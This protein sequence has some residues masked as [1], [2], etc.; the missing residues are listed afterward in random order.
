MM[1]ISPAILGIL[2]V[3]AV[4]PSRGDK[5]IAAGSRPL[6][7]VAAGWRVEVVA[8]APAILFPTAIV[9]AP[10]G[11]IYLGQDPM[12][13][14]GPP[15]RPGDS[16]VA[17]RDG[18]VRV[19]AEGLWAVM[20]LEWIDRTLYVV[21]APF[22]SALT[23]TDGDGRADRRVDLVTGLGPDVPGFSGINDHVASG[24]RL[25]SD[26]FLYVAVGDKGIPHA[27]GTDG[28]TIRLHGGGVVRVR[29]D[30][31]GLEVVSTGERNPLSVALGDRDEVFTYGNDDDSKQWPNSLTHHIVGGHYGYPYEFLQAPWRA[32][33]IVAGDL[34][35]S[36]TQGV[37]LDE[38]GFSP[39]YR[40][41]LAFC[42]WGLQSVFRYE[43]AP[44]GATFRLVRREPLMTRG[45]LADFRPFSIAIDADRSSLLV[46]DWAFPGWLAAGPRTGRLFRLRYDGD[47]RDIAPKPGP[48]P[49][50]ESP[51]STWLAALDHPSRTIRLEGQRRLASG[52]EAVL[53]EVR[54][55]LVDPKAPARARIHA[56]WTLDA[57]GIEPPTSS[58]ADPS[59]D[60][61]SESARRAGIRRIKGVAPALRGLLTDGDPV[62]RREAAIALGRVGSRED[63]PALLDSISD[64]DAFVAW[65]TRG[66]IRALG[67]WDGGSLARALAD[68]ARRDAALILADES[69]A[70][71]VVA[72]LRSAFAGSTDAPFR[73]RVL[74]NLAGQYRKYP[75]WSGRWFGTNPLA[76]AF[77]TRTVDWDP[78]AMAAIRAGLTDGLA[79]REAEVRRQA[80]VG[81]G[82]VGPDA[83]RS[84]VE[85]FRAESD[86]T[87]R[88]AIVAT[89]GRWPVEPGVTDLLIGVLG[90]KAEPVAT[91]IEAL[92]ALAATPGRPALNARFTLAYDRGA[93]ADLVARA[94]VPLGRAGALPANDLAG[95]LDNPDGPV[96]AAAMVGFRDGS[97]PPDHVRAKFVAGLDDA[98]PIARSAAI[99]TVARLKIP[100]AVDRLVALAGDERTRVEATRALAIV[101]DPRALD[102][103][104]AAAGDRDPEV[105]KVGELALLAIRDREGVVDRL[106]ARARAGEF[107]GP[108]ASSVERALA[109]FRPVTTWRVIG[110]F[111]R[112]T[113]RVFVGDPAID[114]ARTHAGVE[115]RTI[116][117]A[118][119]AGDA[120]TGRVVIDEFK[121]GSGDRGGFGYDSNGSPDLAAFAFA[122]IPSD[123]ERPA[124]LLVG[125]SGSLIVTLNEA[126]IHTVTDGA[127]RAYRPD[128]D[129]VRVTLRAGVNRLLIRSRQ[130]IGAWSFGVQVSEPA[131]PSLSPVGAGGPA[132]IEALRAFALGH[133][134]DSR[135]GESLFFDPK[136]LGCARCHA[137]G[138]RGVGGAGPDLTGLALKYDKAEIV[139]SVIQPSERFAIGYR[140]VVVATRDGRVVSGVV[141]SETDGT[142]TLV[143]SEAKEIVLAKSEIEER[144]PAEASIMPTGLVDGLTPLDFADL[145]AYLDSLRAT[146]KP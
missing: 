46:V 110:P 125:S 104:L 65:S 109:V 40:G 121:A 143:D 53:G 91:R 7:K 145:I 139:R 130:G 75:E 29:P 96:R 117:W 99:A 137:A 18:K 69:W 86:P 64:K 132:A 26:G 49:A 10:D 118:D 131:D 123:R 83:A 8:E 101:P 93:P 52:G 94:I 25:G 111:A 30:G 144:R 77:P 119:R 33:P 57:A 4:G 141:R 15:T 136:G 128:S 20:G 98:D 126:T 90:S 108:A 85:S 115:G 55:L 122:E 24:L 142:L 3:W 38:D 73:A 127:G 51:A 102:V 100:G 62:V 56:L 146:T 112:T 89:L 5:P 42:D 31:T 84:L 80:I 105:R 14:P 71:P 23:D 17:I 106:T 70:P 58:L 41:N 28:A 12:D 6:P 133:G 13:M 11:T 47:A 61:R 82:T 92:D 9:A 134:G 48:R 37:R 39:R 50:V 107:R 43:L 59:A 32:L 116:A 63:G 120:A 79:D 129:L 103:Y 1:R 88:S 78:A 21:H 114:F 95:F 54:K 19:F 72:A 60:V 140:P 22:L 45:D 124:M 138:G 67:A 36:G 113:A 44:A 87:N 81:L 35:G 34:G 2:I 76:G 66:A 27:R 135:K 74:S 16:V 97:A 68:P